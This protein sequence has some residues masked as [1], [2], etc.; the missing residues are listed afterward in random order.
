MNDTIRLK[1]LKD[2]FVKLDVHFILMIFHVSLDRLVL[3]KI[4]KRKY[5][6][7]TMEQIY[8]IN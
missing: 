8:L 4:L 2:Y 3:Y 6:I 5:F 7:L 1:D